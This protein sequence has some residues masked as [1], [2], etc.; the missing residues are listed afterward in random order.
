VREGENGYLIS[1]GD[2]STLARRIQEF[3]DDRPR[4]A[5]VGKAARRT[6]AAHPTWDETAAAIE[7]Y[8]SDSPADP[9]EAAANSEEGAP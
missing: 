5:Q 6:W 9:A 2:V 7:A 3:I 1:P 8:L 4:L